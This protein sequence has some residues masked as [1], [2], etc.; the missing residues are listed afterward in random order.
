[1]RLLLAAVVPGLFFRIFRPLP[2]SLRAVD[3]DGLGAWR[4][5]GAA[6][7]PSALALRQDAQ[8]VQGRAQHRPKVM[9]PVIRLGGADAEELPQH[10]L[11]WVG[12]EVDQQEQEFVLAGRQDTVPPCSEPALPRL[13]VGGL[14]KRVDTI[15][16]PLESRQEIPELGKR[17]ARHRQERLRLRR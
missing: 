3:D 11:K 1:M 12:L 2:A 5:N 7:H 10:D 16:S 6:G 4:R 17:Q 15:V 8:V 13:T 14:I 9:E